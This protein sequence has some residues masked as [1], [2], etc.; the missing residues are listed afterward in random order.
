MSGLSLLLEVTSF[1]E[2]KINPPIIGLGRSSYRQA[3]W[4]L[5]F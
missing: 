4:G 2:R 5:V 1:F 3:K